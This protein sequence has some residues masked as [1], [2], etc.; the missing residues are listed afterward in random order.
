MTGICGLVGPETGETAT[1]LERMV[2]ALAMRGTS[3]RT[4]KVKIGN[5]SYVLGVRQS[6]SFGADGLFSNGILTLAIDGYFCDDAIE[7]FLESSLPGSKAFRELYKS[8]GAYAM[9]GVSSEGLVG[10]RDPVGQKPLY[11]GSDKGVVLFASL[12]TALT[13]AGIANPKPVPPG[14]I[15]SITNSATSTDD[16]YRLENTNEDNISEKSAVEK[17]GSLLSESAIKTVPEGSA[18]AF[19][20][21]LDST[22]VAQAAMLTSRRPELF[23]VGLENQPELQHAQQVADQMGLPITVRELTKKE[24]VD[25]VPDVVQ[26][27]ESIDPTVVGVSLPFYATC[28][29]ARAKGLKHIVAGQLSDELFGGYARFEELAGNN[30]TVKREVWESLVSA[31][32]NDF[33]PGDKVAVTNRLDLRCPFAYLP[34]VQYALRIPAGFKVRVQNG[35]PVRKFI[36]RKLASS[37]GLPA[38]VVDRPKRAIQY[39]TGVMNVLEKEAKN[40][41]LGLRGLF[42]EQVA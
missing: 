9:L 29:M 27:T 8:E 37:W 10:G 17:L 12:K 40:R 23:T 18:L 16:T 28:Q 38:S 5:T 24:V 20:G 36:L 3:R 39:S 31:S 19:S 42:Q 26:A 4:V 22:L 11:Y 2:D 35:Q 25:L 13:N 1:M 14:Q 34:L 7:K 21:G 6:P 33:E 41:G 15:V 30:A 32:A